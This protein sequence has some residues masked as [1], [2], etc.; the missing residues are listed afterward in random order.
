MKRKKIKRSL[1]LD[2]R[3]RW[4]STYKMIKLLFMY[5]FMITELFQNKTNIYLTK[6]HHQHLSS[7]E[8]TSDCWYMIELLIKILKPLYAATKVMSGSDYPTIGITFYAMRR[9]E[10]MCS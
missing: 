6:K 1:I 10:T 7:L 2:V 8:F 4:N 9:I 5:R 3:T